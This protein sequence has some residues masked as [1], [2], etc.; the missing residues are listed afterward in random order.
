MCRQNCIPYGVGVFS[1]LVSFPPGKPD[2]FLKIN[3]EV[4]RLLIP[5]H[6]TKILR[7]PSGHY[8]PFVKAESMQ[9]LF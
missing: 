8:F 9:L 2:K 4:F 3:K 6:H 5:P 1:F 7:N